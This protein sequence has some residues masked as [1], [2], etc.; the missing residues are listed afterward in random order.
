MD[1]M[2]ENGTLYISMDLPG[3]AEKDIDVQVVG[4]VLTISGKREIKREKKGQR[5]H[6]YERSTGQFERS[7]QL[8][9]NIDP[10]TVKAEFDKGVLAVSVPV[11][12]RGETGVKHVAITSGSTS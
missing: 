10:S 3:L 2:Q 4:D 11:P 8:P 9:E 1:T 6:R 7:I 12:K 5:W